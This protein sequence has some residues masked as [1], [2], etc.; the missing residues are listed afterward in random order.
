MS[1]EPQP[2]QQ[3]TSSPTVNTEEIWKIALEQ[4]QLRVSP[5]NFS[6][7]FKNTYLSKIENGIA[8]VACP[9]N[10]ARE[11]LDTNHTKL[12]KIILQ[13]I[14]KTDNEVIFT[15]ENEEDAGVYKEPASTENR[16]E[17]LSISPEEAPIF[18]ISYTHQNLV[19][20]AQQKGALNPS[21]LFENF[22]VGDSNKLAHAASEAVADNP[23]RAYNPFFVYGGVGLGKTHLIQAIGNRILNKDPN[24]KVQYCPSET[25]LNEMVEAIRNDRTIEFR[26]NYRQLDTLI[27]DDIQFISSWEAA[28]KEL[29]HTFNTLYQANKQIILASDRPPEQI[30]GLTDRLKSRFRG[31][32]VADINE[33]DYELRIAIIKQKA[34]EKG[35]VLPEN[36]LTFIAKSFEENI[37]ELEGSL[38]RV[39]T[40]VKYGG[41]VPTEDEVAK[42]LEIDAESKRKRVSPR[43]IIRAVCKEFN[44][45]VRDV[46]GKRRT[47]EIVLPR[48]VCMYLLRTE[49]ELPLEQVAKELNRSDHTTVLHAIERVEE[50]MEEDEGFKGRVK[51]LR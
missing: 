40:H 38:I 26:Q 18:N 2:A 4:I 41:V 43:E 21:Y 24:R 23:G 14:T 50:R 51:G 15:V 49:L 16:Y 45:S 31:G 44:A 39:A 13:S 10:Y 37:R 9:S 5:Q 47:A 11:W 34:E 8:T 7:W 42:I 46:R 36:L 35:I 32:M 29:F 3:G 30:D 33:P 28:Q 20:E 19:E 1:Q 6:A 12:I 25:F 22:V 27:I 48:Q 17:G